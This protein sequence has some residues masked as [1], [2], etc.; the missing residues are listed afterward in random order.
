M[1]A[2]LFVKDLEIYTSKK[3]P[4]LYHVQYHLTLNKKRLSTFYIPYLHVL[5][6]VLMNINIE[7]LCTRLRVLL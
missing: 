1:R 5:N 6:I 7:S 4:P 2:F 3:L